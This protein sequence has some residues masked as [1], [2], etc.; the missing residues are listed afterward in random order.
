MEI[1][2]DIPTPEECA[3]LIFDYSG[4]KV[5]PQG[6]EDLWH[7]ILQYKWVLSEKLG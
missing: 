5:E 1:I 3:S 4:R 7:K 2:T 6:A